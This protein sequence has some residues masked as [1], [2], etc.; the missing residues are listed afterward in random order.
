M[1]LG[2]SRLAHSYK[3]STH[4]LGC[5]PKIGTGISVAKQCSY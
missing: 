2:E 5:T 4:S 3:L 1:Y